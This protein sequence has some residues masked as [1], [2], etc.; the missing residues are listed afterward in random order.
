MTP[1]R[2]QQINHILEEIDAAPARAHAAILAR[3]GADDPDLRSQVEYY[4]SEAPTDAF[5]V[6]AIGTEAATLGEPAKQ[7]EKF[8][9]YQAVRLIGHGGMGA[10]YEAVRVDDFHKKVALKVIKQGLDSDH[11]RSRFLQERQTLATLEHPNIA[12]L[13][14]GGETEDSSPYLVLEFVDGVPIT[15]YCAGL[16]R[17]ARLRLFL[18]VCEAVEYAHRNLIVHRDLKPA[19]ILVTAAG[20][21]KLLDF[22][23][24][25]L[26]DSGSPQT[27]TGVLAMTPE[28]ASPEQVKGEPI[29]TASDVYSLGVILYQLLTGRKPYDI[30]NASVL[31]LYRVVCQQPP[32]DPGLG[33]EL[34]QILLMALRKEPARR[35]A[36]VQRL[37]EDIARYLQ[38]RPVSAKADTLRYRASKFFR[39]Y[40]W[41][42]A[43][44]AGV[45]SLLI[46]AAVISTMQARRAER[47]FEDVRQ[48]ANAFIIDVNGSLQGASTQTREH[49]VKTTLPFLEKLSSEAGDDPKVLTDLSAAYAAIGSIQSSFQGKVEEARSSYVRAI[50][51][52]EKL[53]A[54]PGSASGVRKSLAAAYLGLLEIDIRHGELPQAAALGNKAIATAEAAEAGNGWSRRFLINAYTS[55]AR[56]PLEAGHPLKALPLLQKALKLAEEELAKA[57]GDELRFRIAVLH[58]H[59]GEA[60]KNSGNLP[61]GIKQFDIARTI[62][63][64][65][66]NP[67]DARYGSSII[68]LLCAPGSSWAAGPADL[69]IA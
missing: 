51:L 35:Y 60:F 32:A 21:P 47:R 20:E 3:I 38:H 7:R 39:R 63:Q 28:Y 48:L 29:T 43:G 49:I 61:D 53:L 41:Q 4:L 66:A 25:K 65:L 5:I 37:A 15:Q 44:A 19:N 23:I 1:E 36:G 12:R 46:G 9:H 26:L 69:K 50:A 54:K 14:D 24:A 22:G 62:I 18:K 45:A 16:G 56:P 57:P 30:G 27:Q 67:E 2:W 59:I 10:V 52:G 58:H 68:T 8:G 34:D 42:L 55:S 13:L 40:W 11:A 33:D 64:S 17:E 6:G 31:D